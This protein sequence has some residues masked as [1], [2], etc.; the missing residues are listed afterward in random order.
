MLLKSVDLVVGHGLCLDFYLEFAKLNDLT[1]PQFLFLVD[2]NL[3]DVH[4]E[5]LGRERVP[6]FILYR[7]ASIASD[8]VCFVLAKSVKVKA[9]LHLLSSHKSEAVVREVKNNA[10]VSSITLKRIS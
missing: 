3:P 6:G 1:I 5:L 2:L 8:D 10:C 7:M 4:L 9:V